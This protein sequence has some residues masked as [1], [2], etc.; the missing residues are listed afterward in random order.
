MNRISK[1]H[2]WLMCLI[3]HRPIDSQREQSFRPSTIGFYFS[4]SN[5]QNSTSVTSRP[6]ISNGIEKS[7]GDFSK[8]EREI[9]ENSPIRPENS[10]QSARNLDC[11]TENCSISKDT[12]AG[13]NDEHSHAV[14]EK[15]LEDGREAALKEEN[16]IENSN[17]YD[18]VKKKVQN[19]LSNQDV[20]NEQG[21]IT[22]KTDPSSKSRSDL[23]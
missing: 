13:L 5:S 1:K 16:N 6:D 7:D 12:P 15:I 4:S 17:F 8:S 19:V 14:L 9:F 18:K 2:T 22:R 20:S 23:T 11:D 21:A 3:R 10:T